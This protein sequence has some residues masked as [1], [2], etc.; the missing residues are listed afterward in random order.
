MIE[1]VIAELQERGLL[2]DAA[3]ASAF[4]R[5]KLVGAR[6]SRRRVQQQL[7]AK[8]VSREITDAV[9]PQVMNEEGVDPQELTLLVARKKLR[10]LSRLEPH[11]RARRLYAFLARR[12]HDADHIR[13]AMRLVAADASESEA[14]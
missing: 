3:F 12:G 6:Q 14:D 2:D 4:A 11:L 8:G 13:V 1:R 7:A 9:V 5:A 10:T